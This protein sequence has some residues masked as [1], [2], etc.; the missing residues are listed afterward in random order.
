MLPAP[1]QVEALRSSSLA[2]E[3]T[4]KN[5]EKKITTHTFRH[6][7]VGQ[8][9]CFG[10]GCWAQK[11]S[12]PGAIASTAVSTTGGSNLFMSQQAECVRGS[13]EWHDMYLFCRV[14]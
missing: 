10:C 9:S 12:R 4:D 11:P 7:R 2:G 3:E 13:I 8:A 14:W 1:F 6:F 5:Q